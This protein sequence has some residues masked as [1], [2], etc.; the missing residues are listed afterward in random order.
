MLEFQLALY[1]S[2]TRAQISPSNF[3]AACSSNDA[4]AVDL[5]DMVTTG[6]VVQCRLAHVVTA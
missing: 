1:I 5:R 4:Y 6:D 3:R 2:S